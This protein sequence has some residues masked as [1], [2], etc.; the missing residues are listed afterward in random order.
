MKA[1]QDRLQ[2]NSEKQDPKAMTLYSKY[3][4]LVQKTA[5]GANSSP[6]LPVLWGHPKHRR[7]KSPF[8]AS[9]TQY[10]AGKVESMKHQGCRDLLCLQ[11]HLA[12]KLYFQF[13]QM[14]RGLRGYTREDK[15]GNTPCCPGSYFRTHLRLKATSP[16]QPHFCPKTF[17]RTGTRTTGHFQGRG[18]K[19]LFVG[20]PA[21]D[22]TSTTSCCFCK[23]SLF[24]FASFLQR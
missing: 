14:T 22:R 10:F 21:P 24:D 20:L 2:I 3:Q 5:A 13:A 7:I 23:T 6:F 9:V 11:G 15:Y 4:A 18:E 19:G 8:H 12:P 1:H 16:Q 17:I